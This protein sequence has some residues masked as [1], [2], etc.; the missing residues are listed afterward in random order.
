MKTRNRFQSDAEMRLKIS[1]GFNFVSLPAFGSKFSQFRFP[2]QTKKT[3]IDYIHPFLSFSVQKF[4]GRTD[5]QT[6]FEKVFFLLPDQEYIHIH[7]YIYLD[8]FSNFTPLWPKLVYLFLLEIGMKILMFYV[9]SKEEELKMTFIMNFEI[10]FGIFVVLSQNFNNI[11]AATG[12]T[13]YFQKI[14]IDI[15][16]KKLSS[17]DL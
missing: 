11:F 9:D 6:F 13:L 14:P 4:C 3:A 2:V 12:T 16:L 8:Y 5:G 10:F 15:F 1:F 17:I 7:V